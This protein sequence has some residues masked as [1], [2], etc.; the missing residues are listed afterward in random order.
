MSTTE[1]VQILAATQDQSGAGEGDLYQQLSELRQRVEPFIASDEPLPEMERGAAI[2]RAL[3]A[4]GAVMELVGARVDLMKG[5]AGH[6]PGHWTRDYMHALRLAYDPQMPSSVILP[7]VIAGTLHDLGTVLLDR[8]ADKSRAVRHAEAGALLVRAAILEAK[9]L[10]PFEADL[11]AYAIAGHTHYTGESKIVCA[12][13]VERTVRPFKDMRGDKPFMPMWYTRWADRLDCNG[14]C[15]IGRHY[16][17]LHRDHYD[18]G[19]SSDEAHGNFYKITYAEHMRPI[20]RSNEEIKAAGGQRTFPE[21]LMMF[22]NSQS[23]TSLYGKHDFGDMV[24][25]RDDYRLRLEGIVDTI[26]TRPDEVDCDAIV[27]CWGEFLATNIEPGPRG[28]EATKEL[29]LAFS[30]LP[31]EYQRAWAGGFRA[32]LESY[33]SWSR[34]RLEF[35]DKQP[36]HHLCLPGIVSDIR[37]WV[38][39]NRSWT[40]AMTP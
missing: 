34:D 13:G 1:F 4:V 33:L 25:L 29:H 28:Y 21:H 36:K 22:A 23:A 8:Y 3:S 27:W 7:G 40:L 14:P 10:T 24:T 6:G 16:L 39:P 30:R 31:I 32:A 17:T 38:R 18:Y 37:E 11:A 5:D 26:L 19:K 2:E 15:F 35:L 12:D 9:V 20:L